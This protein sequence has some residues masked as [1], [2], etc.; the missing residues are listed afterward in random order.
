MVNTRKDD[1]MRKVVWFSLFPKE[2]VSSEN[3]NCNAE[4]HTSAKAHLISSANILYMGGTTSTGILINLSHNTSPT[5]A[6]DCEKSD[7][8]VA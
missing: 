2:I 7:C 3:E 5:C 6:S 8:R 1:E 4:K